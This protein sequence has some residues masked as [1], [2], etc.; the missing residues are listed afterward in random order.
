MRLEYRITDRKVSLNTRVVEPDA[1]G[2]DL[3]PIVLAVIDDR[4]N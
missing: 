2:S 3:L 4:V 1:A